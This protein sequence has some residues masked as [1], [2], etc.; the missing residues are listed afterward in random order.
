MSNDNI[1]FNEKLKFS[2]GHIIAAVALVAVAY[3]TFVGMVYL[4]KGRFLL[5]GIITAVVTLLI[6]LLFFIPQQLKATDRHFG[7][8]LK[9]ERAFIFSSPVLFLLLMVPFSHAWTVHHRQSLILDDFN[10]IISSAN[11]M[12]DQ[13][14]LYSKIRDVSYRQKLG[15]EDGEVS[16]KNFNKL[17]ILHLALLS[18]N[19]DSLKSV[20][21][22]WMEKSV[23]RDVSTW[24]VFLLGNLTGIKE[25]IF[26]WY[27][28]LRMFSRTKLSEEG[29]DVKLFDSSQR[30]FF[31]MESTIANTA[32]LYTDIKGFNPLT[33]LWLLIVYA[34]L[35]FPYLLQSRHTKTTGTNLTLFGFRNNRKGADNTIPSEISDSPLESDETR[36]EFPNDQIP[37][38]KPGHD[39]FES[40]KM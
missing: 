40:F 1:R 31:E 37:G 8:R 2:W 35:L 11:D 14:E 26:S 20:S 3:C 36:T 38:Q 39:S 28:D 25:A 24:N 30:I 22:V 5:S 29:D 10:Q 34:M 16:V 7:R 27:D 19:Y 21:R 4:L 12:F 23:N 17:E 33:L 6:A 32:A 15:V 13:Y 18:Q 9:W